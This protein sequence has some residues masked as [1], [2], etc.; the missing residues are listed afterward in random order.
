MPREPKEDVYPRQLA[1]SMDPE[2]WRA[3]RRLEAATGLAPGTT[4][5]LAIHKYLRANDPQ[6]D[7]EQRAK[8]G[9]ETARVMEE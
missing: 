7:L 9:P 8:T 2:H 4:A 3:L 6:F 1:V 5:R